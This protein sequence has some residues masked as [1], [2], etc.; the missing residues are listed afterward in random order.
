MSG[1]A[2]AK[3]R[4]EPVPP[5]GSG[6]LTCAVDE[7]ESVTTE[8]RVTCVPGP[9]SSAKIVPVGSELGLATTR[10]VSPSR[11]RRSTAGPCFIPI[12]FGTVTLRAPPS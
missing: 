9:G 2:A 3:T 5:D 12:T 8:P 1:A 6:T 7:D 4:G 10:E 11:S